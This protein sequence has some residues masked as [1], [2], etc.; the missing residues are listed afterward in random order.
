MVGSALLTGTAFYA[1]T[2]EVGIGDLDSRAL[3]ALVIAL[4]SVAWVHLRGMRSA[5]RSLLP[6]SRRV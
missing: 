4:T 6:P 2:N 5:Y 1:A 3:G